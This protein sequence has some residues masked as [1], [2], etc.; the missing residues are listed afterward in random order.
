MGFLY[1]RRF[2]AGFIIQHS[3][4]L[5][6]EDKSTLGH[7]TYTAVTADCLSRERMI[8]S[9]QRELSLLPLAWVPCNN[10]FD[11]Q[12][13]RK[14]LSSFTERSHLL[15]PGRGQQWRQAAVKQSPMLE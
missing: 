2:T 15:P 4:D 12:V 8:F 5:V 3:K 9:E 11:L 13:S 14:P 10:V 1:P 6:A 7:F